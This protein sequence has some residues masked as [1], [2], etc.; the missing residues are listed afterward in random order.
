MWL[1]AIAVM[2]FVL[3]VVV[4]VG[5]F[6][7][8]PGPLPTLPDQTSITRSLN[9]QIKQGSGL[10]N[11]GKGILV[12][13][14]DDVDGSASTVVAATFWVNDIRTPSQLLPSSNPWCPHGKS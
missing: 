4:V 5:P 12:R 6:K 13:T 3:T 7:S 14:P 1:L 11:G 9:G 10:Y 8:S 2:A